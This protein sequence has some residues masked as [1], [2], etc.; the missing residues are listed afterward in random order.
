M[1][2]T[3][4][5]ELFFNTELGS[6]LKISIYDPKSDIL[7]SEVETAMDNIINTGILSGKG[8]LATSALSAQIV[9]RTVNELYDNEN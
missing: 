1:K 5:L 2:E 7:P 4:I 8:G 9:T 3:T 6:K